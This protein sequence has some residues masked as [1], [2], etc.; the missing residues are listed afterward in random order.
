MQYI[1]PYHLDRG[2][3]RIIVSE[4]INGYLAQLDDTLKNVLSGLSTNIDKVKSVL[5]SNGEETAKSN[6]HIYSIAIKLREEEKEKFDELKSEIIATA[7]SVTDECKSYTDTRESAIKA[8]VASDYV[9]VSDFGTY[10]DTIDARITLAEGNIASSVE[11]I[12]K[13]NNKTTE[14]ENTTKSMIEQYADSISS[15][16]ESNF[17]SKEQLGEHESL[18]EY[19]SSRVTQTESSVT[20]FFSNAII[21]VSNEL[22]NITEGINEYIEETNA[23]IRRGE[24]ETDVYG[25]EIGRSDSNIK[26][27]FLNDRISFYQGEVEVAYISDNS[28]YIT[29]AE[30][31]DYLKLGNSTDGYFTFDVSAN[32]LEVRWNA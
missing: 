9:A 14:I 21:A 6:D 5:T 30:I 17:I 22:E 1:F 4:N 28:L 24:L 25:I 11:E 23:Y 15:T 27:R 16:V 8:G 7:S 20:D 13:V 31:L 26:T 3:E 29:R 32:G 19:V 18:A 2:R 10:S 12:E